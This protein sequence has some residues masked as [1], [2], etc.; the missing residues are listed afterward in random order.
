MQQQQM[1][2]GLYTLQINYVSGDCF[3]LMNA[4]DHNG[5]VLFVSGPL[6]VYFLSCTNQI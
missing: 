3:L 1:L 2:A 4:E 5:K 6:L